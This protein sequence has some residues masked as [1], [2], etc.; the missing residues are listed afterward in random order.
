MCVC[1]ACYFF[2]GFC[3]RGRRDVLVSTKGSELSVL[4]P[5][6]DP[7]CT[8][9]C[10]GRERDARG[11]QPAEGCVF[12]DRGNVRALRIVILV[13]LVETKVPFG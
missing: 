10:S 6:I 1:D 5:T 7:V 12:I 9:N 2:P 8:T 4:V 3:L 11:C 13:L